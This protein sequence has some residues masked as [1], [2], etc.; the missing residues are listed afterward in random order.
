LNINYQKYLIHLINYNNFNIL[1][2]LT[3]VFDTPFET[4]NK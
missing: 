2:L 4:K 1:L 3:E